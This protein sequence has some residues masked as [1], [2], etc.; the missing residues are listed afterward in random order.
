MCFYSNQSIKRYAYLILSIGLASADPA[1]WPR[2]W[3]VVAPI[4]ASL[5][6]R[7]IASHVASVTTDTT[8]DAGSVVL[9]FG[10]VI[11]PVTDLSAVLARLIFVVT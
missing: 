1:D 9:L 6:I 10:T 2:A 7:T 8:D 3:P 5:S 11:F 4:L